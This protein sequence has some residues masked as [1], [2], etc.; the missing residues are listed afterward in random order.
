MLLC[1][2]NSLLKQI[3]KGY[4]LIKLHG[5]DIFILFVNIAYQFYY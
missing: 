3:H 5:L 1:F 2:T 4:F